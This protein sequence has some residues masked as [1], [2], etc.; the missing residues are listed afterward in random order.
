MERLLD[1]WNK[2]EGQVK[3]NEHTETTVF[4]PHG[5][6]RAALLIMAALFENVKG[7]LGRNV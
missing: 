7:I 1:L 2:N 6:P 5:R 4:S 3:L